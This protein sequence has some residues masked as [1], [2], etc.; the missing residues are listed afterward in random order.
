MSIFFYPLTYI[1]F[2]FPFP[3]TPSKLP[4]MAAMEDDNTITNT[5]SCLH[6]CSKS[7][8][9]LCKQRMTLLSVVKD[10]VHSVLFRDLHLLLSCSSGFDFVLLPCDSTVHFWFCIFYVVCWLPQSLSVSVCLLWINITCNFAVCY[11]YILC[12]I[13][14]FV[15]H[16]SLPKMNVGTLYLGFVYVVLTHMPLLILH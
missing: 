15:L 10:V 3:R 16:S 8:P 12:Q 6:T 2:I 9:Q 13:F 14:Y 11:N 4:N 5:H 1:L 7:H